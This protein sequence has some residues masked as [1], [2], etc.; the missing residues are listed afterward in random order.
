MWKKDDWAQR[1]GR[2]AASCALLVHIAVGCSE[3]LNQIV[4]ALSHTKVYWWHLQ[5]W[6]LSTR[7]FFRS[8]CSGFAACKRPCPANATA[9]NCMQLQRWKTFWRLSSPCKPA[10]KHW[11]NL[12]EKSTCASSPRFNTLCYLKRSGKNHLG[13]SIYP[14]EGSQHSSMTSRW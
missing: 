3:P 14:T 7:P 11:S 12:P 9:W 2:A 13:Q 8:W 6:N 10:A 1:H 5:E 4:L